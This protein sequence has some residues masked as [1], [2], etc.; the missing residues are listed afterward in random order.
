MIYADYS[1]SEHER[2]WVE[3]AFA[4]T[5]RLLAFCCPSYPAWSPTFNCCAASRR[6]SAHAR[7]EPRR[8][9]R[10]GG[11]WLSLLEDRGSLSVNA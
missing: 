10:S 2:E 8:L 1:Q 5:Y 4:L 7:A 11:S 6:P 3:V 9:M